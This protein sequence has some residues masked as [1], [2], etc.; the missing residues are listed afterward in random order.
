MKINV[1]TD[2]HCARWATTREHTIHIHMHITADKCVIF[3]CRCI[4]TQLKMREKN[5]QTNGIVCWVY[6]YRM[7]TQGAYA[8]VLCKK[9]KPVCVRVHVHSWFCI[10]SRMIPLAFEWNGESLLK[11]LLY[12]HVSPSEALSMTCKAHKYT[13]PHGLKIDMCNCKI[14]R[15]P[16]ATSESASK[17]KW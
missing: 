10:S 4:K 14:Q 6:G 3:S 11:V 2:S 13:I 16:K 8:R 1:K 15:M 7:C 17:S 12:L 9:C 5:H